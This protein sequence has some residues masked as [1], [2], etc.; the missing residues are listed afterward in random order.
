MLDEIPNADRDRDGVVTTNELP[1]YAEWM[2][3]KLAS[4]F[5]LLVQRAGADG[6]PVRPVANLNQNPRL[7]GSDT[8]FPLVEVPR[9]L[10]RRPSPRA[11]WRGSH[12]IR[13]NRFVPQP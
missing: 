12:H 11:E 9:N 5:P 2:V 7:Q 10:V 3:P 1:W 4:N 6:A 13:K 8:S